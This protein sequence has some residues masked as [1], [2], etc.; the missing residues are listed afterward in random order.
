MDGL[1]RVSGA[2]ADQHFWQQL[3]DGM[4]QLAW[5]NDPDGRPLWF[6]RSWLAFTGAPNEELTA[7]WSQF[8]HPDHKRRIIGS[9]AEALKSGEAWQG[10]YP[11]R[12]A[13]GYRW[14]LGHAQPIRDAD[15]RI[16]HWFGTNTDI[17]DQVRAEEQA[18]QVS[19]RLDAILNN[20][21]M[22]VFLMDERQQCVFANAGAEKLT[23]YSL[24]EMQGRP[25]HDVIHHKK[26]DGSPYPLAE[27]PIDRAF[28]ERAQVQGEELFVAPDG[29]LYPVAFTASPLLN[30]QG[31][32]VGTIIEAR[33]IEQRKARENALLQS[34][35]QFRATAEALPGML[36]VTTNEGLN[37]Y[38]NEGFRAFTGRNS[39]EL[40]GDRWTETL[41]PDDVATGWEIWSKA[42]STGE[43]YAAEYRFRRH[44]G[45]W[46][47]H[48]V[49][50]L[51]VKNDD[52]TVNRWVGTCID[53]HD[54]RVAEDAL[55]R[56]EVRY[57]ALF[58]SMEQGF[59]VIQVGFDG[60]SPADY[61][62]TELNPA[63]TEQSGLTSDV[64][65]RSVR[66]AVPE[67]EETWFER[68]GRV[69][70]TGESTR[71]TEFAAPLGRWFEVYAFRIG[72]PDERSVAILFSDVTSRIRQEDALRTSEARLRA[73]LDAAPVGL[74]FADANGQITG[75]NSRVEEIIG[76]R[77]VRSDTIDDY[78]DDYVAFH[79][80]GKQVES[81]DYPLAKVISGE[82]KR[83]ELVCHVQRGDGSRVWVRYAAS[84]IHD[85]DGGLIGGVV[86][87]IDIDKEMLL[88]E[89]LELEVEKVVAEREAAQEALR[90]SQKLEA[91][92]QLTGGV[93]H[94]FNNLLTPIIGS[95]DL[96]N[97]KQ[98]GDARTQ[99]L[100]DGALQSAERA[101][102]LVQRL[103]AFARR[104]PLKATA[105]DVGDTVR[106][107]S[108]LI[109]STSGPRVKVEVDLQ[110]GLPPAHADANQLEMALLNLSVN[111][112]DAMPDG[113]T[114]SIRLE[115]APESPEEV[116]PAGPGSFIVLTVADTGEGMDAET[117]LRAIE[118][119][120]STKGIGKG[121]GLGL[122]MVHG[123]AAQL[124][125]ALRIDSEVGQGTRIELWLPVSKDAAV[126]SDQAPNMQGGQGRGTVLLVDDEELVRSSTAS[127]LSDL[128]FAVAEAS[129]AED[130]LAQVTAG[131]HPDVLVTDQLM[132]GLNGTD[133][134]VKLRR[135][136]PTLPVL[137]VS[138]YA[139]AKSLT[140]GFPHLPKPF[141]HADLAASIAAITG[142]IAANG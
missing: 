103:L 85:P 114:L 68:Y 32:P 24:A 135:K 69:A 78:K 55:R 84:P 20:T 31:K 57:R 23:G 100:V 28:P 126:Q 109:A 101:K 2:A 118:P 127:M 66:E 53:I 104:Q 107:M 81:S 93:A 46:R 3:A 5:I 61:K 75:G 9:F 30:D 33:N 129:S 45:E 83:A 72:N 124:G 13:D 58:E 19:Q 12:G 35:A 119:F 8:H 141:R 88:T 15:G 76:K 4:P 73:V 112:R 25:L 62:F 63:F 49:R 21:T 42:V 137:V 74:V 138:G 95:L 108:E 116:G 39:E 117:R 59:C 34:E 1:T 96:L 60:D 131:L 134:A 121:T 87:S 14:F 41:H 94:D 6:N 99:R 89:G 91:M 7:N 82:K 27:C 65:H 16:T 77:V 92:G 97:R 113:G 17:S 52:G 120:F 102:T 98:V 26:P 140:P 136:L 44:D 111:A 18:S 125:G 115:L 110:P 130:A 132:P 48:A 10:R 56:S 80:G 70:W 123:L 139:D 105:V 11:L 64:L 106:E 79:K 47:W 142:A 67:L 37:S 51:P 86:A 29:S 50:A 36:F 71:F 40:L 122:S 128:G 22:G 38:V 133:L 90:Q 54:R 43:P